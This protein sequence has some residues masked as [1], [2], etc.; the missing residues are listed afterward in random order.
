[1]KSIR[2]LLGLTLG[3]LAGY[4]TAVFSWLL[5]QLLEADPDA[6][7][8]LPQNKAPR[9]RTF[10]R[11]EVYPGYRVRYVVEDGI[12]W[13]SYFPKERHF[14]T[15]LLMQHGMF[16]GAWCWAE[17][18]A[19]FA[20]Q[21]W[22]SHA[23]SLPGHGNSPLQRP[24][25]KC[26]LDYYLSFLRDAAGK[27]EKPPV[28]IGH[29]MGGA[30]TQWYIRYVEPPPAAV[31]I[32]SWVADSALRDGFWLLVRQDPA[33][34]LRMLVSLDSSSW[35]RTP[36]RAAEKFLGPAAVISPRDFHARL[37]P[38]SALVLFQHNPP[39]WLPPRKMLPP[40]LWLAGERDAV[41]SVEGLRRSAQ[42]FGGD[43]LLVSDAGHNLMMEASGQ[44][45]VR[46]IHDW[47]VSQDIG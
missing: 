41:V 23:I 37:G 15:P 30:L 36:E 13:V 12:E 14:E 19:A 21:G 26:T 7:L 18:Q 46:M 20:E 31:F 11:W 34:I 25:H 10:E 22:E 44:Q 40:S 9:G 35:I 42:R 29:S 39:F 28:I 43:F 45:M 38:E 27:L 6:A 24:I 16:H 32:A 4:I 17:W 3:I 5:W 2:G 47:L 8:R 1:M 33:I